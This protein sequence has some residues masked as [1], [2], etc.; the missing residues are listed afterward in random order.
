[1]N[2][3]TRGSSS[4][5]SQQSG[6]TDRYTAS[7]THPDSYTH[8]STRNLILNEVCK[9]SNVTFTRFLRK[10][11]SGTNSICITFIS[12]YLS[13]NILSQGCTSD[14]FYPDTDLMPRNYPVTLCLPGAFKKQFY[15]KCEVFSCWQSGITSC[16]IL[17]SS[18]AIPPTVEG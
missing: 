18:P 11:T 17:H 10:E 7:Q 4:V 9:N 13:L 15:V 3:Q 14:V 6:V 5:K 1:M 12:S 8:C 16:R 2:V